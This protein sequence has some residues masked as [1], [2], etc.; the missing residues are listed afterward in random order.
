[1]HHRRAAWLR[2]TR[3]MDVC[4]RFGGEE[5]AVILPCTD[6]E[7]ARMVAERI[8]T[9]ME[10]EEVIWEGRPIEFT[11]SVGGYTAGGRCP[12]CQGQRVSCWTRSWANRLGW[13]PKFRF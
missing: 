9:R 11:V 3:R 6:E 10:D 1:M 2:S 12:S 5:F 7:P 8:R 4:A 13:W